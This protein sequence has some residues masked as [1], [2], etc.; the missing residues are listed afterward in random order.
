LI[1]KNDIPSLI[2]IFFFFF[3]SQNPEDSLSIHFNSNVDDSTQ[4]FE[5]HIFDWDRWTTDDYIGDAVVPLDFFNQNPTGVLDKWFPIIHKKT[6]KNS[7]QVH[8]KITRERKG[9][10]AMPT[11][12]SKKNLGSTSLPVQ[13]RKPLVDSARVALTS[14]S[15]TPRVPPPL[16]IQLIQNE[17]TVG[18]KD[19]LRDAL[20]ADVNKVDF[21][22]YSALHQACMASD[23]NKQEEMLTALLSFEGINVKATIPSDQNTPLHYLCQHFKSPDVNA[24]FDTF[25]KKGADVN[26]KNSSGET[27]LFKAIFNKSIRLLLVELLLEAGASVN[28]YNQPN[29]EGV[30]HYAV[31]LKR[32]DLVSILLEAGADISVR[33]NKTKKTPL[34]IALESN[35]SVMAGQLQDAKGFALFYSCCYFHAMCLY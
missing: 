20:V 5:L 10:A 25:I 6:H 26:A 15:A 3:S 33:E 35:N 24:I 30:L 21:E 27:P 1:C 2:S 28:I 16:I 9:G 34:E 29:G 32:P 19:F 31:R 18:L 12:P 7:G 8:L 4:E 11:E 23:I 17:D 14:S 13:G 22:G